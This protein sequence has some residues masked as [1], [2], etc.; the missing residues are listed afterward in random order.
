MRQPMCL[1]DQS[2]ED[3]MEYASCYLDEEITIQYTGHRYQ[4]PTSNQIY[5]YEIT[6]NS[7]NPTTFYIHTWFYILPDCKMGKELIV[8]GKKEARDKW[9]VALDTNLFEFFAQQSIHLS[10]N[11]PFNLHLD[12]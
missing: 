4:V 3:G 2:Q 10:D 6:S 9:F 12:F 8:F 5:S 1:I 7:I 11:R